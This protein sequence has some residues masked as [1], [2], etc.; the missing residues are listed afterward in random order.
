MADGEHQLIFEE[1][2][3]LGYILPDTQSF[4]DDAALYKK[5][6]EGLHPHTAEPSGRDYLK[7]P[8]QTARELDDL[9]KKNCYMIARIF[10]ECFNTEYLKHFSFYR[11]SGVRYMG[12]NALQPCVD[13]L[14]S[15]TR[16]VNEIDRQIKA[17]RQR[18]NWEALI[19]GNREDFFEPKM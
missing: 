12:P 10:D 6:L 19:A 7:V 15:M 8:M 18:P 17:G 16:T 3:D 14:V 4:K 2:R 11:K 5:T 1:A 13:L 9:M